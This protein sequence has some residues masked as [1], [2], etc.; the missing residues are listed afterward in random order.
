MPLSKRTLRFGLVLFASMACAGH[1]AAGTFNVKSPE[2]HEGESD[3]VLEMAWQNGFPVNSDLIRQS[4]KTEYSYGFSNWFKAGIELNY[5]QVVGESFEVHSGGPLVQFVLLEPQN[6][7]LGL[8]WFTRYD[9]GIQ[10]GARDVLTFGPLMSVAF[11]EGLNVTLNPLFKKEWNPNKPGI[12]SSYSWQVKADITDNIGVGVEG[13]GSIPD[14]GD[15]P[16][17]D[18]QEHR[19]GPV[20]YLVFDVDA[21][22]HVIG[23]RESKPGP[24][25][26][27]QFGVLFGL[28]EATPDIAGKAKLA[29][30]F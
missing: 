20:A 13:Y 17:I 21:A 14:I 27:L 12:E 1:A 23:G 2:V 26:E 10:S 30:T 22:D 24:K 16:G 5:E 4:Y 15:P 18:F 7:P 8:A 11:G 25:M 29:V 19:I 28:T 9:T 6:G 3:I